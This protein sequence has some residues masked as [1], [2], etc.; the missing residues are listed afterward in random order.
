M[1]EEH[2]KE[3]EKRERL[4]QTFL[5]IGGFFVAFAEGDFKQ[6]AI[7]L[8]SVYLLFILLYYVFISRGFSILIDFFAISS[9]IPYSFL[10]LVF[11][12]S[13]APN[14]WSPREFWFIFIAQ[15]CILTFS[16]LSPE[17][18]NQ[19]IEYF[20]KISKSNPRVTKTVGLVSIVILIALLIFYVLSRIK[21]ASS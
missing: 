16:L 9:S 17:T 11:F 13:H 2:N 14:S 7:F 15:T 3:L 5:T 8:F 21:F 10:I 20:K 4:V 6:Y 19:T 12:Y 1:A 18:S